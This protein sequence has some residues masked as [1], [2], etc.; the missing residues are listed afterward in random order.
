MNLTLFNKM[1]NEIGSEFWDIAP[2]KSDNIYLLSGRTALDFI[3]RDVLKS[4]TIQS[5]LLPSYCC[6]TM[7][8]PFCRHGVTVRFYDVFPN[9]DGGL[10]ADVPDLLEHEL[11]YGMTYFG[12]E[13][14]KGVQI[15]KIRRNA[16][17][18]VEDCTHS[19]LARNG[20][21]M[22]DY[23]YTSYRKWAGFTGIAK[24]EK[25][26]GCFDELPSKKN[27]T[28]CA[29]R[30]RASAMKREY[31]V[32]GTGN[33]QEFLSLYGE[34]EELL[35]K[36][37]AGYLPEAETINEFMSFDWNKAKAIRR[38][39]AAVL[40]EDLKAVK[41]VRLLYSEL[42]EGDVPLFVPIVV[43]NDRKGLRGWLTA[44]SI[45]CPVHWPL[46]SYHEGISKR[47]KLLYDQELSLL[48]DQRYD[49]TDMERIVE[50]IKEYYKR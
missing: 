25:Y 10:L 5:A 20:F 42:D 18:I 28:Y 14:M 9:S 19:W 7:I 16:E 40:L 2:A 34:A 27:E 31:I 38:N 21:G 32:Q 6:H 41:E 1:T 12:F 13:N 33:K 39:N 30:K 29:M 49:E 3:I 11:F 26:T 35:D 24:A 8:E 37:Y 36:D 50:V 48:C 23:S 44:H 47:A 46:S 4:H 43:P 15:E 17:V 22:A 45:Y